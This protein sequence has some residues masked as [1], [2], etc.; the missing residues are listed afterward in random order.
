MS[1]H[2]SEFSWVELP[3]EPFKTK[4]PWIEAPDFKGVRLAAGEQ[5]L[6]FEK[7]PEGGHALAASTDDTSL[8]PMEPSLLVLWLPCF[9]DL[10]RFPTAHASRYDLTLAFR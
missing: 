1:K 9:G 4:A 5:T 7:P 8:T 10:W 6:I 2:H 3:V